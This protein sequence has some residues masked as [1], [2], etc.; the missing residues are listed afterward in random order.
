[1]NVLCVGD[2]IAR[3][4]AAFLAKALPKLRRDYAADLVIVNGENSD[5]SGLG[6]TQEGVDFLSPLADVITTGNH[7]FDRAGEEL[8]RDNHR[9]LCPANYPYIPDVLGCVTLTLR[10]GR[11]A[12]VLNLMGLVGLSPL[13][14]P[15]DRADALLAAYPADFSILDFHAENT[16]E[17]K[18]LAAYLDGRISA[19]FCTHTHV[20]TADEQVLPRGTG[21][22][23]D[24][25]MT[26]PIYSAGGI[27]IEAAITRRRT[28]RP[29]RLKAAE[30]PCMLNAVLFR[31]DDN[32]G[33]CRE[34][35]RLN[36]R[37]DATG[38]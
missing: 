2:V 24:A 15:F 26:G 34:A 31:L 25:G 32:T 9:L 5:D 18:A 7:C 13:D 21:F 12:T 27:A 38:C 16:V 28:Q 4:G 17:K 30:G 35:L 37:E 8:Y 11:T 22:I 1:M 36:V 10:S 14:S 19:V 20:Q 33:L 3:Q 6:I 29:G 23:S